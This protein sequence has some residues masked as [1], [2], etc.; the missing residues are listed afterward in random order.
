M[1]PIDIFFGI[2]QGVVA[3]ILLMRVNG[4]PDLVVYFLAAM[5]VISGIMDLF[6]M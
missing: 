1:N 4:L 5:L 6:D 2:I 3:V